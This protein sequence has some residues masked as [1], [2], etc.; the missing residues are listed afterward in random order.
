MLTLVQQPLDHLLGLEAPG[1]DP[2]EHTVYGYAMASRLELWGRG[3]QVLGLR[4]A[5]IVGMHRSDDQSQAQ[6]GGMDLEF[7]S[8]SGDLVVDLA[9]FVEHRLKALVTGWESLVIALCNPDEIGLAPIF[10]PLLESLQGPLYWATGVVQA[11]YEDFTGPR[12]LEAVRW[13][14]ESR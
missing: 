13:Y 12:V 10:R 6:S 5:C 7:S 14:R 11:S 3:G 2:D 1:A 4:R 8:E 9:E